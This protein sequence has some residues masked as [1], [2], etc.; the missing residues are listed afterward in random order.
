[1]A[2]ANPPADR[3]SMILVLSTAVCGAALMAGAAVVLLMMLTHF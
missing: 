3:L 2:P 1:M